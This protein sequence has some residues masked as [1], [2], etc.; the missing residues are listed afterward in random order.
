MELTNPDGVV[1]PIKH[2]PVKVVTVVLIPSTQSLLKVTR[3]VYVGNKQKKSS[4]EI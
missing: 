1:P 3:Q 4:V 2:F